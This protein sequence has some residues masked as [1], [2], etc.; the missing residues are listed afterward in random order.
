MPPSRQ[1]FKPARG[2]WGGPWQL[3]PLPGGTFGTIVQQGLM[4]FGPRGSIAS[5]TG[6]EGLLVPGS[7]GVLPSP[8]VAALGTSRTN[9]LGGG[10][11]TPAP[12]NTGLG[13][14]VP[15][16]GVVAG[17]AV[18]GGA[19]T[20][21]L[22]IYGR[23]PAG[24]KKEAKSVEQLLDEH[25]VLGK[26]APMSLGK[27][28]QPVNTEIYCY[29]LRD[30]ASK[31]PFL[32][33]PEALL[34]AVGGSFGLSRSLRDELRSS[35][36]RLP[37]FTDVRLPCTTDNLFGFEIGAELAALT[38]TRLRT[39]DLTVKEPDGMEQDQDPA[40]GLVGSEGEDTPGFGLHSGSTSDAESVGPLS[41]LNTVN[42]SRTHTPSTGRTKDLLYLMHERIGVWRRKVDLWIKASEQEPPF[43]IP[44]YVDKIKEAVAHASQRRLLLQAADQPGQDSTDLDGTVDGSDLITIDAVNTDVGEKAATGSAAAV[45]NLVPKNAAPENS[46]VEDVETSRVVETK[47]KFADICTNAPRH[48]VCRLF[49]T[50][51]LLVNKYNLQIESDPLAGDFVV[52]ASNVNPEELGVE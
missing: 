44:T 43:H 12:L 13:V 30:V 18:T 19:G 10:Q 2:A 34:L 4:S 27:T 46:R 47:V 52:D 32:A 24:K 41:L 31:E 14:A 8:S 33:S 50:T 1:L 15:G 48:D 37:I 39:R 20:G 49:L 38:K 35:G 16:A 5:Q 9:L 36:G 26:D 21:G 23:V 17:G 22:Q 42:T 25:Q 11:T 40:E 6:A 45:E 29:S 7:Q 51:L 3:S 28:C